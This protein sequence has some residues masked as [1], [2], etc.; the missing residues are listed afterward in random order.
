MRGQPSLGPRGFDR[1]GRFRPRRFGGTSG[2]RT[3]G[4][5]HAAARVDSV[6]M[7]ASMPM[8]GMSGTR[9]GAEP[10]RSWPGPPVLLA[11]GYAE[12]AEPVASRSPLTVEPFGRTEPAEAVEDRPATH[13]AAVGRLVPPTA[14]ARVRVSPVK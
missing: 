1:L 8:P 6:V 12:R 7:D 5:P 13:A 11:T 2:R 14:G 4:M 3:P 9:L 10:R